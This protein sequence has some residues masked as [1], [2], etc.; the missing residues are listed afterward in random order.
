VETVYVVGYTHPVLTPSTVATLLARYDLL[1]YNSISHPEVV[2]LAGA[3]AKGH[4]FAYKLVAGNDG[5]LT[6]TLPVGVTPKQRRSQIA[7]EITGT[8]ADM[9]DAKDNFVGLGPRHRILFKTVIVGPMAHHGGHGVRKAAF[10]GHFTDVL[11]LELPARLLRRI[12]DSFL[13]AHS[14]KKRSLRQPQAIRRAGV[15]LGVHR[16]PDNLAAV[17][18]LNADILLPRPRRPEWKRAAQLLEA[19]RVAVKMA[20]SLFRKQASPLR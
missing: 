4:D 9:L 11:S 16:Q 2:L 7:L 5:C 12:P 10:R 13:H 3:D 15:I 18:V 20:D 1:G 17:R 6:V 19:I 14:L 8:D